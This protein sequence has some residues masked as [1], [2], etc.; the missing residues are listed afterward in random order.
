MS[1]HMI[2]H[3]ESIMGLALPLALAFIL[4]LGYGIV[5]PVL[6]F[7]LAS[8]L[9]EAASS[10]VAWHTGLLTGIYMLAIFLFAP[11]WGYISDRVGRRV[12]ILVGLAGFS[13]AML[14]LAVV[15]DIALIYGARVLAG[16]FAAAVVP[17]V[18]ALVSDSGLRTRA[19]A[20]AWLSA[21][22]ALGF[23][24][25]PALS[26][27]LASAE[28]VHQHVATA[29][30]FYGAALLGGTAWLVAYRF[31]P[32]SAP[33]LSKSESESRAPSLIWLLALSMM[34]MLGLGGYEVSVALQAQ[35]VL[36]LQ[37]RELGWMFAECSLVMILMQLFVLGPLLQRF[38]SYLLPP[39]F[40]AMA[41][42]IA[43]LPY[44]TSY[45]AMLLGVGLVAAAAGML[46]PAL[47]YLVSLA[48]GSESGAAIGRQT[49]ATNLGQAVGSVAAGWLFT[50]R[51]EM[52]FWVIAVVLVVG[53][54]IALRV[55]ETTN[56]L[57]EPSEREAHE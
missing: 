50:V 27:W 40:L 43:L 7:M 38:G 24:F 11:V 49:A 32:E 57:I 56:R 34:V 33:R 53:A 44:V 31:L 47:V 3:H 20:F 46:I 18:F 45:P 36:N 28:S 1:L 15:R 8:A 37:P 17:V 41:V 14:W 29:L 42:G 4:S 19:Q 30:P 26:G 55:P 5:L 25:G 22:S 54:V 2:D 39:A 52:P 51:I 10:D 6:P 13:A 16:I 48:C 23:L 9:G 12:V 21:A 35:Q